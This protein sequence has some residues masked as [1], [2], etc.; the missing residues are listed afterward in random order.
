MA[1]TNVTVQ[2]P[3]SNTSETFTNTAESA[4]LLAALMLGL[5]AAQKSTKKM[6]R[7]K[8]AWLG[9]RNRVAAFFKKMQQL[10]TR[11][12]LYILLGLAVLILVF[13]A[14]V[15]A[16]ILLLVGILLILLLKV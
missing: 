5:Y 14:P 6:G 13:V 2:Q 15:A 11:T 16:I 4:S 8:S 1:L 9:L 7:L 10:S 3:Q 12:I